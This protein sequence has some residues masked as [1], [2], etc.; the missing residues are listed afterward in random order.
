MSRKE[1]QHETLMVGI[2]FGIDQQKQ[3]IGDILVSR[4]L[5]LYES[6]RIGATETT[7][8]GDKPHASTWLIDRL[9]G[10]EFSWK[11]AAYR[12]QIKRFET[13]AIGALTFEDL[14]SLDGEELGPATDLMQLLD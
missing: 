7:P 12:D 14:A 2:A 10:A 3:S 6:Q 1:Q 11:D 13:E 9:R 8:R 5:W 4:Q